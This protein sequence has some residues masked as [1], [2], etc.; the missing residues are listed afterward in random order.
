MGLIRLIAAP[1]RHIANSRLF[2]LGAVIAIVLLLENFSNNHAVLAKTADGLDKL[3]EWTVQLISDHFTQLTYPNQVD[4][5]GRR[6]DRVRVSCLSGGIC[7][8]PTADEHGARPRWP[9]Q[10]LMAETHDCAGPR[11]CRL[12]GLA[13]AGEDSAGRVSADSLGRGV[14]VA[15]EW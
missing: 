15:C 12:P 9:D 3:V 1:I 10:L 5:D 6:D 7:F 8:A 2:Q 14:R 11:H 4:A 13:A